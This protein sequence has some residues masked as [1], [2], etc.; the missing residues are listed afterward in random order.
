MAGNG[1]SFYIPTFNRL[2]PTSIDP[3]TVVDRKTGAVLN[4]YNEPLWHTAIYPLGGTA[5][6]TFFSTGQGAT[7]TQN[8]GTYT[9][10]WSET[11]LPSNAQL[12]TPDLY[13]F[14][15]MHVEVQVGLGS[16]EVNHWQ[17]QRCWGEFKFGTTSV[18]IHFRMSQMPQKHGLY[19]VS[20]DAGA[21]YLGIDAPSGQSVMATSVFSYGRLID[22][23]ETFSVVLHWEGTAPIFQSDF[24][25]TMYLDGQYLRRSGN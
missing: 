3:P 13:I 20:N 15:G 19:G 22:S 7:I 1:K 14:Y 10:T 12:G 17:N 6:L 23:T 4:L 11:N 5:S 25:A 2:D 24:R 21:D 18:V 9:S 16:D 8:I